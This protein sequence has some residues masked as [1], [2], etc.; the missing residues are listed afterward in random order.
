MIVVV[1]TEFDC[2]SF[3][4]RMGKWLSLRFHLD[5]ILPLII[6]SGFIKFDKKMKCYPKIHN[7]KPLNILPQYFTAIL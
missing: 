7:K 6:L 4:F 3:R 1:K 5:I 2:I